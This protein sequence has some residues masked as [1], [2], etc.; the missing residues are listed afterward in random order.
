MTTTNPTTNTWALDSLSRS[1]VCHADATTKPEM[2]MAN[3][4][5]NVCTASIRVESH[6]GEAPRGV[7]INTMI[8]RIATA[9]T[10]IAISDSRLLLTSGFDIRVTS[11]T[12]LNVTERVSR[13]VVVKP[14]VFPM[15]RCQ[16]SNLH[17]ENG[18]EPTSRFV[19]LRYKVVPGQFI[20]VASVAKSILSSIRKGGTAC[21]VQPRLCTWAD[22]GQSCSFSCWLW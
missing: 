15:T 9:Q 7:A 19:K 20:D 16:A 22:L 1:S 10:P 18:L 13:A 6:P 3:S 14:Q 8:P 2:R 5:N 12:S 17:L 21:S 11:Q 4:S